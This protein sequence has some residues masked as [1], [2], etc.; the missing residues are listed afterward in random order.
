M[1]NKNRMNANKNFEINELTNELKIFFV[2]KENPLGR[3]TLED[4]GIQINSILYL[5]IFTIKA[6]LCHHKI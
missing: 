2:P 5:S 3:V 4:V 1:I 6:A